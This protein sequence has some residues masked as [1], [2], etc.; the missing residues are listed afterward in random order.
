MNQ[1]GKFLRAVVSH[2]TAWATGSALSA[3]WMVI[4]SM[5]TVQLSVGIARLLFFGGVAWAC[6]LAWR[7]ENNARLALK[8]RLRPK[9]EILDSCDNDQASNLCRV[10]VRSLC[11]GEIEFEVVIKAIF[12][13]VNG[14]PLPLPLRITQAP[15]QS[16][17]HLPARQ[18]RTVDVA[19]L[20]ENT[21]SGGHEH[22]SFCGIGPRVPPAPRK[23][24]WLIICASCKEGPAVEKDFLVD[25]Q[26]DVPTLHVRPSTG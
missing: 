21:P 18:E 15:G 2:W 23:P 22:I 5:S 14:M 1:F 11:D 3:F 25:C 9:L 13:K 19:G 7:D 17:A 26:G 12:P 20:D 4:I 10:R 8:E 24:Y 6:W 16:L